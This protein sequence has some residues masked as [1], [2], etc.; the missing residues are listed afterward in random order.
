MVP[1]ALTS[2]ERR[3]VAASVIPACLAGTVATGYAITWSIGAQ[4][5]QL[6]AAVLA[7]AVGFAPTWV[8]LAAGLRLGGRLREP[9][10]D[11][12]ALPRP[13]LVLSIAAPLV[14]ATTAYDTLSPVDPWRWA[15]ILPVVSATFAL[16]AIA[17]TL[18]RRWQRRSGRRWSA[19]LQRGDPPAGRRAGEREAEAVRRG[20]PLTG[21]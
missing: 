20:S 9:W 21:R 17:S 2:V 8:V 4:Q 6:L 10:F 7:A 11:T 1:L 5:D 16:A 12:R 14:P 15:S 18:N 13:A 19:D 3:L